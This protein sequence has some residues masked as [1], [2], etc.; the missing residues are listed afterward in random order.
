MDDLKLYSK[1]EKAL[2]SLIHTVKIISED[3]GMQFR[4]DKCVILLTK[5]RKIVKSGGIQLP[6]DKIIKS[7]E[8][9]ESCKYLGGLEA[10]EVMV[11]EM[12]SKVKKKCYG[13]VR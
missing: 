7:L 6:N 1:S 3:I 2:Y 10:D 9:G 11:N 8:E 13:R 4:I 12:K 5:N